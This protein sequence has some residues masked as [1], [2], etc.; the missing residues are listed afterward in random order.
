MKAQ[1]I[2]N[3]ISELPTKYTERTEA[4]ALAKIDETAK[5]LAPMLN[6]KGLQISKGGSTSSTRNASTRIYLEK[7]GNTSHDYRHQA[8]RENV[9]EVFEWQ[10]LN[11]GWWSPLSAKKVKSFCDELIQSVEAYNG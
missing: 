7:V 3:V 9:I 2:A 8:Y 4:K 11:S 5:K 10:T 1:S 6:A